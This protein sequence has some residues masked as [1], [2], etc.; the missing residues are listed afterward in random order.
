MYS[1]PADDQGN[2]YPPLHP[3]PEDVVLTHHRGFDSFIGT[4]L[5][6]QLKRHGIEKVVLAGFTSE[7]C[8]EGTGRH[9]LEAGYHVTFLHDAVG[10]FTEQ[11]HRAALEVAYPTFGHES[12]TI[13]EFLTSVNA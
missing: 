3:K 1:S 11:A 5:D 10:E 4:D 7:T 2:F 13:D 12:L 8:V 6:E 9:A